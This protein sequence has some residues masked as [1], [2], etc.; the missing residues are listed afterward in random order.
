MRSMTPIHAL[1]LLLVIGSAC[2]AEHSSARRSD[3]EAGATGSIAVSAS[4]VMDVSAASDTG[5][6]QIGELVGA[7]R[8]S[9][10]QVVA[11]DRGS[12]VL[13]FFSASGTPIRVVGRPGDGP[14]EYKDLV[15]IQQCGADTL[16]AWDR[17]HARLTV[18]DSAGAFIRQSRLPGDPLQISCDRAGR[19]AVLA[20]TPLTSTASP[21][22]SG[23]VLVV[24]TS[25]DSLGAVAPVVLGT[26]RPLGA[27]TS[28]ALVPGRLYVGTGDSA[29]VD[30]FTADGRPDGGFA[31]DVPRRHPTSANYDATIDRI[32]SSL[33]EA[34]ARAANRKRLMATPMP[35][36]VPAYRTIL[37]GPA[38][39][40]WVVI[41]PKGDPATEI[42][43][44]RPDGTRLAHLRFPFDLDVYEVGTDYLLGAYLDAGDVQHLVSYRLTAR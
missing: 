12:S 43:A 1:P 11:A 37:P 19:I 29:R 30:R 18:L 32:V 10:G 2:A 44:I 25:G 4:P 34:A 23:A 41:S 33:R 20:I 6:G 8:L 27:L 7:T 31:L 3:L 24:S 36:Y 26:N 21:V 38:G 40:L 14:G 16:Y 15:S 28:I 39:T 17:M 13:R 42:E 5:R 22:Y 35:E 9:G